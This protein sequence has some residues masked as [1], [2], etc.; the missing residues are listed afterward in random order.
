M[1]PAMPEPTQAMAQHN[2]PTAAALVSAGLG[3]FLIGLL[4]LL[5]DLIKPL[6]K[7]FSLY[8]PAGALSGETTLAVLIW[9]AT[10]YIL[11][12]RWRSST[13]RFQNALIAA[14]I[15][16]FAGILM[17]FPPFVHML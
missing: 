3:C 9:L 12:R 8:T 15:L 7:A 11:H 13:T 2:G 4:D 17:T 5:A 14:Y 6:N 16:L 1:T 10:W